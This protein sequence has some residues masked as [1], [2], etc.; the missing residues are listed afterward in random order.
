LSSVSACRTLTRVKRGI[1]IF[2]ALWLS[3]QPAFALDFASLRQLIETEKIA[4]I[5]ELL[6]RLPA[7]DRSGYV[8]VFDSRSLQGA[9]FRDP[10]ALV[11]GKDAKF[12]FTFNGDSQQRGYEQIE[13]MEF[14]PVNKT[15]IFRNIVFTRAG[16]GSGE[17]T[18]SEVNPPVCLGCH[19]NPPRP[20]W[21]TH[22]VWPGVYGENYLRPLDK[23]ERNGLAE[24]SA[25]MNSHPRYRHL[26]YLENYVRPT[27][28]SPDTVQRYQGTPSEPPNAVL[29]NSLGYMNLLAIA[30]QVERAEKFAAYQYALLGSLHPGC[31]SADL[32]PSDVRASFR[33]SYDD[34]V[35]SS[36][37]ANLQQRA[38]KSLRTLR[39]ESGFT[40]APAGESMD[41]FRYLVEQGLGISTS[42]WTLALEKNTYDFAISGQ[43]RQELESL[44]FKRLAGVD[45]A[46]R[47]LREIEAMSRSDKY[48]AYLERK[49]R[50][51][52]SQN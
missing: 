18:F 43:V 42:E 12:I 48:C 45:P 34:F 30:A 16:L 7:P 49:S 22:P 17:I 15:F 25:S 31:S 38:L 36:D 2:C 24:F 4:S 10:R 23:L 6:S 3:A 50:R 13:T 11:F 27:A 9:S 29:T 41:R 32:V 37:K 35:A 19:G 28:F 47:N 52:L 1:A 39:K 26:L 51:L 44:F 46:L 20:I 21:D 40:A 8:L 33:V 14:E 5:E